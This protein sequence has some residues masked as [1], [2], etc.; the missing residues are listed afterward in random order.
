MR[1]KAN[2]F[3]KIPERLSRLSSSI[4][5]SIALWRPISQR[6]LSLLLL[7][8]EK[9]SSL[10]FIIRTVR[11]VRSGENP[12][13]ALRTDP[14]ILDQPR[15]DAFV[16]ISV[17]ARQH[18]QLLALFVIVETNATR[19]VRIARFELDQRELLQL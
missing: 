17:I 5:L 19:L 2:N 12:L 8:S 7:L 13:S 9:R 14:L 4:W 15:V 10:I 3:L 1:A 18:P 11:V 16:V 6:R